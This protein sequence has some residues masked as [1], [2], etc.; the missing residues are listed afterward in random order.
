MREPTVHRVQRLN[1]SGTKM[2]VTLGLGDVPRHAGL[3][4]TKPERSW[5]KFSR[6]AA[7]LVL[8]VHISIVDDSQGNP[9]ALH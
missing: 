2:P 4:G 1:L 9:A 7:L 5:P 8:F 3:L 6:V